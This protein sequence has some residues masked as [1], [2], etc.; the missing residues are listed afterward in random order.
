MSSKSEAADCL[1]YFI[2][3]NP[4]LPSFVQFLGSNTFNQQILKS[5][6]NFQVHFL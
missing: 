5:F 1:N 6:F 4:N 2:V 3:C